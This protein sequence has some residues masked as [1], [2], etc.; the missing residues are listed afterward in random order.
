[1]KNKS[2][3]FNN[4]IVCGDVGTGTTTLSKELAKKLGWRHISAGNFFR[5]YFKKHNIPLWDKLSV[6]DKIDKKI[7]YEL[8][9]R[10]RN[11]K[12]IVLDAHYGGWFARDLSDVLRILLI[13]DKSIA[14]QRVLDREHMHK[15]TPEEIEKRR[16]QLREKF[17]QLYSPDDYENP[18]YFHLIIDTTVT[19]KEDS[20]SRALRAFNDR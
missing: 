5:K 4:I 1:M 19:G 13:C 12:G 20:L 3:H 17:H 9:E 6:P 11:E 16:V 15:E 7:D 10:M 18:K 8:L 14:T 2:K